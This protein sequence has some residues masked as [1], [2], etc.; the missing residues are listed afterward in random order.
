MTQEA[1]ALEDR[2]LNADDPDQPEMSVAA[3]VERIGVDATTVET[4]DLRTLTRLQR[5]HVT[6]V[7][8]ETLAITGDPYGERTG[9]GIVLSLPHL[10]EK[11]VEQE[12]GGY[13][14]EVNG[15]F[16][17]LLAGLGYEVQRAAARVFTDGAVRRIP[18]NHH[19]IIADLDRRFL[20]DVGMGPPRI[21]E[22]LPLNGTPQTDE[23]GV[24]WR[25]VASERPDVSYRTEYCGPEDAEWTPRYVFNDV[26]RELQY[27]AA[28]NDYF[29]SA[30]E[31]PFTGTPTVA[32]ST[33][34]GYRKLSGDTLVEV[35]RS[36]QRERTVTD[37]AWH[38]VLA[39]KFGLRYGAG[40]PG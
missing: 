34:A 14:F 40:R 32:L 39:Q 12:R 23:V 5:A 22:P 29:Q 18:A 13:C 15:L 27:F 8:F 25:V 7:P 9:E 11:I 26:P 30:P 17:A 24:E 1:V 20:V 4:P 19:V 31:S 6:T 36:G 2:S 16:H 3:Y 38:D 21:R 28:T 10:Y 37:D 33:E 35:V